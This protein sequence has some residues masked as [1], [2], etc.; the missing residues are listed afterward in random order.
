MHFHYA[1]EL[2]AMTGGHSIIPLIRDAGLMV[3]AVLLILAVLSVVSWA[4][5]F[6]KLLQIRTA[7][8]GSDQFLE[9]FWRTEDLAELHRSL[10]KSSASPMGNLFSSGYGELRRILAASGEASADAHGGHVRVPMAPDNVSRALYRARTEEVT[11]LEKAVSFLATTGNT[12][13]FIGLFGTVWGIMN[14][15]QGIGAQGSASLAVVAPGISEALV[16]TAMGLFAAIPA[17]VAF[18]HFANKIRMLEADL[19]NFSAEFLNL[20]GRRLSVRS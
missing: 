19:E 17:V 7:R 1:T 20:V 12:A 3:K 5:I 18:N 9:L 10:K 2:I 11:K 13:P 16:A 8:R 14:S 6:V 15:F 4:I